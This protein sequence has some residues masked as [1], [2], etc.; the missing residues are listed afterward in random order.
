MSQRKSDV[1]SNANGR[2]TT[3]SPIELDLSSLD[4]TVDERQSTAGEPLRVA[5]DLVYEDPNNPRTEFDDKNPR[6]LL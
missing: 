2:L 3:R 5:L 6:I 4:L 1:V